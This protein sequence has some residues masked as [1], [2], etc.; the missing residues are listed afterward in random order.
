MATRIGINGFGR[1]G[2]QSLKALI[3]RVPDVE[4][5]AIND[6]VKPE[7]DAPVQARLDLRHVPRRGPYAPTR[8]SSWTAGRS[9]SCARTGS[10]RSRGAISAST[11]SSSATGRFTERAGRGRTWPAAREEGHH[12]RAGQGR[13]T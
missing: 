6:L 8:A 2:R 12:Q 11:S 4:V 1:I 3:E 5:V 9:A 10:T 13:R 7:L